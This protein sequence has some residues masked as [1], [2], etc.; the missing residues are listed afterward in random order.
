[1]SFAPVISRA[2]VFPKPGWVGSRQACSQETWDR[3][4]RARGSWL[5][6]PVRGP[7]SRASWP[8][9]RKLALPA[10]AL[11]VQNSGALQ[12]LRLTAAEGQQRQTASGT[13]D[14]PRLLQPSPG[15]SR[16]LN[17]KLV[18]QAVAASISTPVPGTAPSPTLGL[19]AGM[20]FQ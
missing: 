19:P 1:M 8:Q 17:R 2:F 4:P 7:H 18:N 13:P 15:G 10:Q 6:G 12:L 20:Q 3:P 16:R 5:A 9:W 11:T 14:A